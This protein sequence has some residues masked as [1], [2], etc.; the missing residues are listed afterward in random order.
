MQEW[1]PSMH[2]SSVDDMQ[3]S[4]K[5]NRGLEVLGYMLVPELCTR[6]VLIAAMDSER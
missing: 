1:S 4:P 3:Q 2:R 5:F 6:K